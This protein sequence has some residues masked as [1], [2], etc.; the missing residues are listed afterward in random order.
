[1]IPRNTS[2]QKRDLS[3][4][5]LSIG[6]HLVALAAMTLVTIAGT[7]H[8]PLEAIE[9][10]LT[11]EMRTPE[12][13]TSELN[14]D[15]EIA[16]S[17]NVAAGGA[18][19]TGTEGAG[20]AGGTG[21]GGG[22]GGGL[23]VDHAKIDNSAG[24]RDPTVGLG[25]GG[26][27]I[28]GLESLG[29]DLGA[30]QIAGEVGAV[31][32]GYGAALDRLT[33]EL[34]R[35]M[36]ESRVLVVWLFDESES[37]K[38]DQEELKGR[39]HRVYEELRLFDE[40][41]KA[42]VLLSAVVSFGQDVHFMLPKKKPTDDV[43]TIMKAIDAIPIDRTGV[44]NTCHAISTVIADYR[45]QAAQGKRKLVVV[46]ISDE[47]GD[48]GEKVEETL[49]QARTARAPIYFLGRESVFGHLYAY[50][51]WVHPQTG[52]L[53]YLPI[54]R[55]PETPF[56][57]L[58]PLDGFRHRMDAS[59]SGF[60]PYEQV[61][62]CRDTGG[63][64]FMLPSEEQNINDPDSRKYASLDMKEYTPDI[65]TRRDYVERRDK[66][67]FRR[68]IWEAIV[69]LNPY[70]EKNKEMEIPI[71]NW[72][73]V[74]PGEYTQPVTDALGRCR[75]LFALLTEAEQRLKAVQ[76]LRKGEKSQR[77]RA[78]YDLML[79]QVMAYRVRLFQYWIALEQFARSIPTRKFAD[80]KSNQ[81]AV[82]IGAKDL[83]KP[84]EQQLRAT[85]VSVDDL[86]RARKAALKQFAAVQQEHPGTPWAARAAW[87]L[88]RGFGMTFLE[89][90]IPPPRPSTT[91]APTTPIAPPPKL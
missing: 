12:E 38:D 62:L 69:L 23:A 53:H 42:D 2:F 50:V 47:A 29:N 54:R 73:S 10:I 74:E 82:G 30:G 77:W 20:G 44:E 59:L 81:W 11:D 19:V 16:E 60:G 65:A 52:G 24:F 35:L 33:Q 80:K 89:R 27:A 49:Q 63:I 79:G 43:P 34:V 78:D 46:V 84:D 14:T 22:G 90:Y 58:L 55:G 8:A 88:S 25:T 41:V 1:M 5:G 75:N 45:R 64:F 17:M 61:R 3:V 76:D 40:E 26:L 6:V 70:D 87:E 86:D 91:P 56:A 9:S 4:L 51:R 32:E 7:V 85:K 66:S 71:D 72:Y 57:E 83:L 31:V 39:I 18:V 67:P 13:F 37:M 36:R 68:A 28:P 21:G 15:R 48:D